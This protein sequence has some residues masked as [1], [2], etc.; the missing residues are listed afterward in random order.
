M[1][2][3]GNNAD[4]SSTAFQCLPQIFLHRIV[5]TSRQSKICGRL[6][7]YTP[8]I[9]PLTTFFSL[10]IPALLFFRSVIRGIVVPRGVVP[11]GVVHRE[12]SGNVTGFL[13]NTF[14]HNYDTKLLLLIVLQHWVLKSVT[15]VQIFL[16]KIF[17]SW[18]KVLARRAS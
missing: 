3:S 18:F 1:T 5:R 16:H 17:L 8:E 9:F 12:L 11:H 10:Y 14:H 13:G 15:S 7:I 2:F 4:C 6:S